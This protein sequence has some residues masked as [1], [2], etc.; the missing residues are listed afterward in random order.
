MDKY[1]LYAKALFYIVISP[2]YVPAVI[3]WE[4]RKQIKEFYVEAWQIFSGT[5]P[6]LKEK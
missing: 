5:H 1:K 2:V 4:E 3:L 6:D